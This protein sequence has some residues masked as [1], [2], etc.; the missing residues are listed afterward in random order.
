MNAYE[1]QQA[2]RQR[3][4]RALQQGLQH[5]PVYS[6]LLARGH[7]VS[8]S[9]VQDAVVHSTYTQVQT[10]AAERKLHHGH[11]QI[12]AVWQT[13]QLVGHS[14]NAHATQYADRFGRLQE[15][16]RRLEREAVQLRNTYQALRD[17]AE[18]QSALDKLDAVAEDLTST[19]AERQARA[20][21]MVRDPSAL[22]TGPA[23][24]APSSRRPSV[25]FLLPRQG[26]DGRGG[27]SM[28]SGLPAFVLPVGLQRE[29]Q[30]DAVELVN[31]VEVRRLSS[32]VHMLAFA[33]LA[34]LHQHPCAVCPPQP[35]QVHCAGTLAV[36]LYRSRGRSALA[37]R[38]P[39]PRTAARARECVASPVL[40]GARLSGPRALTRILVYAGQ[41]TQ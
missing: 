24:S 2:D 20:R 33:M 22:R 4:K 8:G 9:T 36:G 3:R 19:L 41:R 15:E 18:K 28:H 32:E 13:Q 5:A 17:K 16:K 14:K 23:G 12:P 34:R 31:C 1:L 7:L 11:G 38:P 30:D 35:L 37:M 29:A 27:A 26:A 25:T 40:R 21:Q 39:P 10:A 6:E